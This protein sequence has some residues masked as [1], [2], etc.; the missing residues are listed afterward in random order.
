MVQSQLSNNSRSDLRHSFG[1][2]GTYQNLARR[3]PTGFKAMASF[4]HHLGRCAGFVTGCVR[5]ANLVAEV[6]GGRLVVR[7]YR[8]QG[9]VKQDVVHL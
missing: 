1:S 3:I 6:T 4:S 7:S 8:E 5:G 2:G 9:K